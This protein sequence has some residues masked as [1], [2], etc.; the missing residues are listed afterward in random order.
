VRAPKRARSSARLDQALSS[1]ERLGARLDFCEQPSDFL[2]HDEDV[3]AAEDAL[4]RIQRPRAP[5]KIIGNHDTNAVNGRR[6][7]VDFPT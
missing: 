1:G 5:T 4:A 6:G 3:K 2:V 7:Q